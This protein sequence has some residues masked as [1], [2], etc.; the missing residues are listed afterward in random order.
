[1]ITITLQEAQNQL[2]Q[3]LQQIQQSHEIIRI[4]DAGKP[5]ADLVPASSSGNPLQPHEEIQHIQI[6]YD[7]VAPLLQDEWSEDSI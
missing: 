5:V 3:W 7:P 2:P 4:L 1:M 6:H